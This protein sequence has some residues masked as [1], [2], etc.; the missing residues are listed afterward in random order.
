MSEDLGYIAEALRPLAVPVGELHEDPT[1]ARKGHAVDR[2]AAS[3]KTYGQRKPV[4]ANRAQN[5]KIEA[6]NG[7]Y[8]AAKTLG[9]SHIA[10]VWVEDDAATAAGYGIADNRLGDL[11]EWDT[12]VL[13]DVVGSLEDMFTG[14][15]VAELDELLPDRK[16]QGLD[17]PGPQVDKAAE[18]QAKWQT[19]TGQ[20]W[21]LGEHRLVCG[22][23]TDAAV[24]ARV[25]GG[26]RAQMAVTS[27]PYGVG[28]SY[29][30]KGIG[31]WFE[32]IRPCIKLLC[33][34]CQ[35]VVWQLGDLYSTGSQHIEPTMVYSLNMFAENGMKPIWIRIWEKQ[36]MNFGVGPYHLVSN[37]PVQQY[38]YI[39]AM[40]SDEEGVDSTDFEWIVGFGGPR[41]KFVR[42]LSKGDRKAWGYAGV[43]KINTVAAND[44]HPAMFPLELPERCIKM[45]SDEGGI[46]MEPFSGS[47]TTLIACERL[48]RRC[49]AVEIEPGYVAV[50]LERWSVMTGRTPEVVA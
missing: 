4:V 10:V 43:W 28:K 7:T 3:L 32:T 11:S 5:G 15:T 12:D 46:V 29:E 1:N 36:G 38:E 9:W 22:D 25:M 40:G 48:G 37:K 42:R 2:I 31:P 34:Y 45:H 18:L 16:G 47:G 21:Q 13:A 8:R 23:C 41:H 27:P 50:A 33:D 39:A 17:D 44:D 49:R 26:E 35:V 20:L 24:V 30:T 6:G 19:A 14:F